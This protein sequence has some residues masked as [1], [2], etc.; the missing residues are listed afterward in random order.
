MLPQDLHPIAA[1]AVVATTFCVLMLRRRTP[2]D[3]LLLGALMLLT[4]LGVLTPQQAFSGFSNQAVLTVAGLFAVTAALRRVGMLDWIGRRLLGAAEDERSAMVR[5][6]AAL[7]TTST[8]LLNTALVAMMMPVVI[9]WCRRRNVSPSRLL[10]PLSYFTILGGVCTLI[11]TS[12]TLVAQ[13]KLREMQ[14]SFA[15]DAELPATFVHALR[16]MTLFEIGRVGLPAGAAGALFLLVV[17]RRLMPNR[18]DLMDQFG[19]QRREY[20]VEMMV[21]SDCQLIG[22]TIEEAGLRHL[23]GLF[24]IEIDRDGETITP[25]TPQDIVRSGD[26]MVFAGVVNTIVDLERIPGLVPAADMNYEMHPKKRQQRQL[27]EVVLSR[28]SPLIGRTVRDAHF[29]QRYNAA[30]VAVH[31]N[32][33]RLTNKIGDIYFQEG[34]TLLLQTRTS[35]VT[36]FRNSRE[37]YLVSSVDGSEPPRHDKLWIAAV[38]TG[39]LV[40]WL[41]LAAWFGAADQGWSSTAVASITIAG[42]M[43]FFRCVPLTEARS[44]L[45]LHTLTTIAAALG[46]GQALAVSGAAQAIA[47]SIVTHVGSNPQLLLIVIYILASLMTETI[48]NNAVAAMLLPLAAAVAWQG[49]YNPRPFCMAVALAASL[50]FVTPIGYQT[51][52]MVMGPGGYRPADYLK[53]GLPLALVVGVVA[54][55]LIPY[56]WPFY[57]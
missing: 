26:R 34:D 29:R 23:P 39:I 57:L 13:G 10:L 30:V 24:L 18:Q 54:L 41:I 45:D 12:T 1:V 16:P 50:S 36:T 55:T 3:L 4:I 28:S 7:L 35:F 27:T 21:Q 42:L 51:N 31:R 20:L 2:T 38:L 52:L 19:D 32:G 33:V 11:G 56:V 25:V 17:G 47:E 46:L 5:L 9:E 53:A 48:T 43:V 15:A 6:A 40:A 49:G 44:S 8:F 22:K 37:F 14:E